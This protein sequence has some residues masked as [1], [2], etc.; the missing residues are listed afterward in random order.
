MAAPTPV[1]DASF[2]A[3]YARRGAF[4]DCYAMPVP[5]A[6]TLPEFIE[7]FYTTRLFKLERW[8]LAKALGFHSTDEQA[9][10]LAHGNSAHFSAWKVESRASDQILLDAG[11]TRSW[12]GVRPRL[13]AIASTTLLFGSAVV[14]MRPG[15]KFGLAFRMLL[16]FHRLYSKLLLA[17]AARRVVA[18]RKATGVALT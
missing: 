12:L 18:L 13:G 17:A 6:I 10:L 11:Q 5:A 8:L 2:L 3:D 7:A 15:G 4:T 9:S 16:G 14:P 1:P